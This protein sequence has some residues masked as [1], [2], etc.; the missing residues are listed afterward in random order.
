MM[1]N[2]GFQ[3]KYPEQMNQAKSLQP[4]EKKS[5]KHQKTKQMQIRISSNNI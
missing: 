3:L 2:R 5:H 4:W 1:M